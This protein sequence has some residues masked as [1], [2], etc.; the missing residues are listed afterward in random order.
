MVNEELYTEQFYERH[1]P[2]RNRYC[3]IANWLWLNFEPKSV[4]D[5]GC[6]NG[7]IISELKNRGAS[8]IGVEGS[9]NAKEFAP[10]NIKNDI[11]IANVT[12]PLSLGKFDL[13]ISSEVAEHL[14]ARSA[15]TFLD[16]L[17]S[18]AKKIIFFTAAEPGQGGINHINEQPHD[19]WIEKFNER[20]F[21]FLKSESQSIR[22]YLQVL[23]KNH[24]KSTKHFIWNSM[25]FKKATITDMNLINR[26]IASSRINVA[27]HLH[28]LTY[29]IQ[30][31]A[32]MFLVAAKSELVRSML[33]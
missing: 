16:N 14:P 10:E 7:Y 19:Y 2:W 6:G 29:L 18:H 12:E 1:A 32:G 24:E 3:E 30:G 4:V 23:W 9:A 8:V 17:S 5:F 28:L 20:G 22:K 25:I 21:V 13:V 33:L 27:L 31:R 15:D 26:Q 11:H